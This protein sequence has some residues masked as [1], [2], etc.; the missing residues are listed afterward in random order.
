MFCKKNIRTSSNAADRELKSEIETRRAKFQM[1]RYVQLKDVH[2]IV[3]EA[4]HELYD[5]LGASVTLAK[6]NRGEIA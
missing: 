4:L 3:K 5:K 1:D 2:V 6:E